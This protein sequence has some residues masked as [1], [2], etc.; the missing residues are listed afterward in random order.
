[1]FASRLPAL[2]RACAVAA[3]AAASV[4]CAEAPR[5][6]GLTETVVSGGSAVA[7]GYPPPGGT[8]APPPPTPTPSAAPDG[9]YP[10]PV[11]RTDAMLTMAESEHS[12]LLAALQADF[13][14]G[15]TDSLAAAVTE[16]FGVTL[17]D[18]RNLDSEGGTH[19][20]G[21]GA[22]ALLRAFADA[23]SRPII[24]GYFES[25][26]TGTR[27]LMVVATGFVGAVEHPAADSPD[28]YGPRPPSQIPADSAGLGLCRDSG[29]AW[30]W[31]DWA[32]G[33]YHQIVER[34]DDSREESGWRYV[35]ILP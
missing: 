15:G 9:R 4:A 33:G 16:R 20:D 29:G 19:L 18:I 8:I 14:S 25:E 22:E 35:V 6:A 32:Y 13:D 11:G 28:P 5:D 7:Q 31:R 30:L 27:C 12:D 24:Q 3:L 23:G 34:F 1:M 26:S 17:F 21:P 2:L 10:P